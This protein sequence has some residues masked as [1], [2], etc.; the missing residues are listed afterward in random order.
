[1]FRSLMPALLIGVVAACGSREV[2]DDCNPDNHCHL[3][4]GVPTC[5]AG[6]VWTDA[7]DPSNLQCIPTVPRSVAPALDT[8]SAMPSWAVA[9]S[10]TDVTWTWTYANSPA[11][12]PSC[13]IDPNVGTMT[14]GTT[15]RISITSDTTY[16]LT[17]SNNAGGDTA[18][19]IVSVVAA[20]F[21]PVIAAFTA[22]PSSVV[23]GVTTD[24]T[25]SWTYSNVPAPTPVCAINQGLGTVTSGAVKAISLTT[26]RTY[27][28]TCTNSAGSDTAQKTISVTAAP[29]A[30]SIATFAATPSS[31]TTDTATDVAWSW[32]YSN[33]PTPA[34]SC[35]ID[36]DVGTITNGTTTSVTLAAEQTYV[37]TCSNSAGS[38]TAQTTIS[39][40]PPPPALATFTAT[41]STVPGGV[42]TDVTW[43]WSYSNSPSP[44]PACTVN[45]QPVTNGSTTSVSIQ[46]AQYFETSQNRM[47]VVTYA[48]YGL[49]CEND[50]GYDEASLRMGIVDTYSAVTA[51]YNFTCGIKGGNL[52]ACW[53]RNYD[54][55]CC[56]PW[57]SP[58]SQVK[59]VS[60]GYKFSCAL[61][62]SG[63]VV[64]AGPTQ[65]ADYGQSTPPAGTFTAVSAGD[66]HA[67]GIKT[68]QTVECWGVNDD[69][70]CNHPTGSFI[71]ISAGGWHTCGIK[72]D[73]TIACWGYDDDGRSTPPAGTFTAVSAGGYHTCGI[74]S[75]GTVSC[76]GDNGDGQASPPT[77]AFVSVSS[78]GLHTCGLKTDSSLA[79]WGYNHDGQAT[80]PSGSFTAVDA[81]FTHSCGI[82]SDNTMT[83]WGSDYYGSS[84][85][86]NHSS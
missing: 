34:P 35:V 75:D 65:G 49:R 33:S 74:T 11:P 1:M 78:G 67:C 23:A 80:P 66:F 12:T 10:P 57:V 24:V 56:E 60:A 5:D 71:A 37:L 43:N 86:W 25:W 55:E 47:V 28:L 82:K 21:A 48:N 81:G 59:A 3:Q 62:V 70:Q 26:S 6:Y 32:T 19:A 61:R 22:M 38:D 50:A 73:G 8:F 72:T 13:D 7:N 31:V 76:W 54:C 20:S 14:S 51:G 17:C 44:A 4:D 64:C 30:P 52:L 45:S 15:S 39:V 68:D 46:S 41:P 85:G 79:C 84:T 69:G 29:V 58:T 9:G 77:G 27:T 40:H 18:Q 2:G 42:P 83:C 63:T 53:G 16:T 36:Q